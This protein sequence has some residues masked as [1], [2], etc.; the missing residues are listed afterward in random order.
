MKIAVHRCASQPPERQLTGTLTARTNTGILHAKL[1]KKILPGGNKSVCRGGGRTSLDGEGA[2][3][4]WGAPIPHIW[5]SP[6]SMAV[7]VS[8]GVWQVGTISPKTFGPSEAPP[9]PKFVG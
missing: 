7:R 5:D 6:V 1:A 4:K 8:V 9:L 3:P 2:T